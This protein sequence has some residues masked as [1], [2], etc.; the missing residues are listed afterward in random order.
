MLVL[1]VK[2]GG[3]PRTCRVQLHDESS[4]GFDKSRKQFFDFKFARRF[5]LRISI[6]S[7]LRPSKPLAVANAH[8]EPQHFQTTPAAAGDPF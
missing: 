1:G 5:W 7:V 4:F 8:V 2:I 6:S 3:R